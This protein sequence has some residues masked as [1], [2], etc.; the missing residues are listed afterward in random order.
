[1]KHDEFSIG[2]EFT[3]ETGRWRCTDIGTRTITAIKISDVDIT[4]CKNGVTVS[5]TDSSPDSSW[6]NGPPYAVAE[7]TFDEDGILSCQEMSAITDV[8]CYPWASPTA[9]QIKRFD[10]LTPDE[11]L[12][13][14]REA[15]IEG[16][17]SGDSG[18]LD[19]KEIVQRAKREVGLLPV[20]DKG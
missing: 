14:L 13:M 11:Q 12:N 5:R 17:E 7:H 8:S 10:Q 16:E 3:T 6:F 19:M 20:D 9:E 4:T 1:M 15:I 2:V 18:I